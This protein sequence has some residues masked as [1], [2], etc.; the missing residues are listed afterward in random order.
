MYTAVL[1]LWLIPLPTDVSF[2]LVRLHLD[3]TDAKHTGLTSLYIIVPAVQ[4]RCSVISKL[5]GIHQHIFSSKKY[6]TFP[7]PAVQN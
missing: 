6:C 1:W 5:I 4:D 2:H 7:A 3:I